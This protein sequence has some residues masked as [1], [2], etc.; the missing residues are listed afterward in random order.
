MQDTCKTAETKLSHVTVKNRVYIF[1]LLTQQI[2]IKL[3]KSSVTSFIH[4]KYQ[5][6][7][8]GEF[9]F[10][11]IFVSS[12]KVFFSQERE[13]VGNFH[14]M[15]CMVNFKVVD[16]YLFYISYLGDLWR[17]GF[18][19]RVKGSS[20]KHMLHLFSKGLNDFRIQY[21]ETN[22]MELHQY[23]LQRHRS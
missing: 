23:L 4:I 2:L 16:L 20:Q 10:L 14:H 19:F 1:S 7:N 11:F 21:K 3:Q 12:L 15:I 18:K 9:V 5:L 17:H 13:S 22:G 8:F 6:L